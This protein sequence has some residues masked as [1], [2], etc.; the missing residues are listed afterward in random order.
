M[1]KVDDL[2]RIKSRGK[3]KMKQKHTSKALLILALSSI[4]I[5]GSCSEQ[6]FSLP[7]FEQGEDLTWDDIHDPDRPDGDFDYDDDYVPVDPPDIIR[8]EIP[9][10]DPAYENGSE[11]AI[12]RMEAENAYVDFVGSN[13][14][15][16]RNE[17]SDVD[18]LAFDFRLSNK[19]CTRN[20]NDAWQGGTSIS[21]NFNSSES[22]LV[23][24]KAL[25]STHDS[26][27]DPYV[28]DSNFKVRS[29]GENDKGEELYSYAD[30]SELSIPR[31]ESTELVSGGEVNSEYFYFAEIEFYAAIYKGETSIKF[32]FNGSG[33]GCNLDYIE[34]DTSA[35]ISG[36]DNDYYQDGD[37]ASSLD[38]K[39]SEWYVSKTPTDTEEGT[40]SAQK[41]IAGEWH[42]YDYGLPALLDEE[43]NLVNGYT[44][45]A[46]GSYSFEFKKDKVT[47]TP[48]Q[49]LSS[50]ITISDDSLVKFTG[51]A[52]SITKEVGQPIEASDFDLP[53]DKDL[54]VI[55]AYDKYGHDLGSISLSSWTVPTYGITLAVR[56]LIPAGYTQYNACDEQSNRLPNPVYG[57]AIK[58]NFSISSSYDTYIHGS[59]ADEG[60]FGSVISYNGILTPRGV[61]LPTEN[62]PNPEEA[63][64]QFRVTTHIGKDT[65][66][67]PI[68]LNKEHSFIYYLEN[69]GSTRMHLRL[70]VVNSGN[71]IEP[72]DEGFDVDLEPGESLTA[73]IN[74]SFTLGSSNRNTMA[75]FTVLEDVEN[76]RLG[77][78]LIAK[79]GK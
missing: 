77:I 46:D 12:T 70:N 73:T 22:Y 62:N 24:V 74:I 31:S 48:G 54:G 17:F 19:L 59:E 56:S 29:E 11:T 47:F 32:E 14:S 69:F 8:E 58:S 21:F 5:L 25:I 72:N 37:K 64:T 79:L 76:M 61:P 39:T 38:G 3:N 42:T 4:S 6:S 28:P 27:T 15:E 2:I 65:N 41:Y 68:V 9:D 30:L 63:D 53:S 45:E 10:L 50:T 55:Y 51:G 52:T 33:K 78:A 35:E 40:F 20:L 75:L 67:K 18:K 49:N 13:D 26:K 7:S 23:K 16:W 71:S 44:K 36:F 57:G 34:I 66:D 1:K 43:G 60:L